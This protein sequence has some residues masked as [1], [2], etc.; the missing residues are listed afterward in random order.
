MMVR[1]LVRCGDA[2]ASVHQVVTSWRRSCF[3]FAFTKQNPDTCLARSLVDF[4]TRTPDPSGRYTSIMSSADVDLMT[5]R[6]ACSA[7]SIVRQVISAPPVFAARSKGSEDQM[8]SVIR[9]GERR[10]R[11]RFRPRYARVTCLV[12]SRLSRVQQCTN[13]Y[14]ATI[15][16][17]CALQ[18]KDRKTSVFAHR[19]QDD[20]SHPLLLLRQSVSSLRNSRKTPSLTKRPQVIADLYER[21]VELIGDTE[22][23]EGPMTDGYAASTPFSTQRSIREE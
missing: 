4:E 11:R 17:P 6:T 3:A 19:E 9:V 20:H 21:Y 13:S 18:L 16:P 10:M 8:Y 15:P 23:E 1:W 2:A 7:H 5:A 22:R 12:C 14:T